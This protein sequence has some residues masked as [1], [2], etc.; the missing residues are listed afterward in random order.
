MVVHDLTKS[1]DHFTVPPSMSI[2][3]LMLR[4][5]LDPLEIHIHQ[6]S[7]CFVAVSKESDSD[8]LTG[9]VEW[10]PLTLSSLLELKPT[11]TAPGESAFRNGRVKQ[12][13][14]N[15]TIVIK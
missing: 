10:E 15:N 13:F 5:L 6:G 1:Q 12:W 2:S 8:V 14:L 7:L 3:C 4:V 11:K 9:K